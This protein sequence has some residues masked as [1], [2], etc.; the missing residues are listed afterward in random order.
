MSDDVY[1]K[2]TLADGK[3]TCYRFVSTGKVNPDN[4]EANIGL[5]DEGEL[6][7][8]KLNVSP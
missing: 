8:A 7:T 3:I 1:I 2:E 6:S 5:L 4:R